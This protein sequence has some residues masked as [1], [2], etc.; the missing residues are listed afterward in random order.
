MAQSKVWQVAN[1]PPS[2]YSEETNKVKEYLCVANSWEFGNWRLQ[3]C[4][5]GNFK[6][7]PKLW[8]WT[9]VDL[10][11]GRHGWGEELPKEGVAESSPSPGAKMRNQ[12]PHRRMCNVWMQGNKPWALPGSAQQPGVAQQCLNL[13]QHQI[14]WD[15][16]GLGALGM[17]GHC[18]GGVGALGNKGITLLEKW[19][20]VSGKGRLESGCLIHER[21]EKKSSWIGEEQGERCSCALHITGRGK[22]EMS[23]SQFFSRMMP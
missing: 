4:A 3:E 23:F 8:V 17:V 7:T 20:W 5:L 16:P 19:V 12:C 2:N 10:V 9:V 22:I 1:N 18:W 6:P 13:S 21:E 14:P 15:S 11:P